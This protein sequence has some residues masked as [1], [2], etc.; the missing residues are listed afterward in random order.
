MPQGYAPIREPSE[1]FYNR[2]LYMRIHVR[3]MR[4]CATPA[5][6]SCLGPYVCC[7]TQRSVEPTNAQH[8]LMH[9]SCASLQD[10]WNRPICSAPDAWID[11][12]ERHEVE[13]KT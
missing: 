7:C 1:D 3:I 6:I 12:M 2:R 9:L 11:V 10:C 13:D 4:H 5:S 8:P